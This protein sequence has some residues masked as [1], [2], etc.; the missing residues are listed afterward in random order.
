MAFE[1][2]LPDIGEGVVEAEVQKWF[3]KP[4]DEVLEDQPLVE[5]MT[6]KATVVI[7]SPRRGRVTR[8][9]YQEGEVAKVHHPLLELELEAKPAPAPPPT[10]ST[11]AAAGGSEAPMA[12]ATPSST[13]GPSAPVSASAPLAP[14]PPAS[15]PK[16]L[17][18][19]AVRAMARQMG[20]DLAAVRGTGPGGRVTKDDL[21]GERAPRNGHHVAGGA[22][23]VAGMEEEDAGGEELSERP[24]TFEVAIP[25]KLPVAPVAHGDE[26]V[27]LRG[28][29]RRIAERMAQSKR[30]AAHFT[31]VEQVD[32]TELKR[33][34]DRVAEAAKAEGVRVTFLPFICKATVAALKR[35]PFLNATLDEARG[36]IRLR[37]EFH[38]GIASATEQGLVVPVVRHADRR[39]L[40]DLAR[41]I[42]RLSADTKAGRSRPEDMGGSTFTI[43]SLGAQGGL[44]ATPIINYPEV[45]ILGI[46]RIRPT[47]VVR[48]G[49]IVAR[50]VM[51][52][53]LSFDHRLVD[54]HV[55]AAFA[56]AL[57][58]Y[59]EDPN[60]LFM[61]MV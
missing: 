41:E 19:P 3:V 47:P 22:G 10:A 25:E 16:T 4:G 24:G 44:F 53:S 61:E 57:I 60:L 32:V 58:A 43:T 9:H 7:P 35:Y 1:F 31:F 50:D 49:Q 20:V 18:T 30:T 15:R 17:A 34:K 56:Y 26:V 39:S 52:V 45:G 37:R 27:P 5:V 12:S 54:G 46:H 38:L 8:L 40:L 29:R 36:E 21:Q 33:V 11:A 59:L 48:D 14:Q 6:D 23:Q 2:I 42:E 13:T 51:N 55:G 28:I